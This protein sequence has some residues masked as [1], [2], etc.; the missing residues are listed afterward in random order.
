MSR[1]IYKDK[2]TKERIERSQGAKNVYINFDAITELPDEYECVI[3]EVRFDPKRLE[4]TFSPVGGGNYMPKPELMYEIAEACGIS[5]TGDPKIEPIIEEVDINP[6][7]MKPIGSE[8]TM[9]KMTIGRRVTKIS[10]R[11]QEDGTPRTSSPCT[12][13]YNAWERSVIKFAEWDD[14]KKSEKC[15]LST[16]QKRN[17]YFLSQELKFAHS[18]AETK[19]YEKSIRELA[20]LQTGYKIS[21]LS[22]GVLYFAKIRRSAM[23][24]KLETAARLDNI[25]NGGLPTAQQRQLEA[26]A[27]TEEPEA[28]P[29]DVIPHVEDDFELTP[30]EPEQPKTKREI[31]IDTF[32]FYREKNLIPE[33]DR[34]AWLKAIDTVTAWLKKNMLAE[35][36]EKLFNSAIDNLK[37]LENTIPSEVQKDHGLYVK[38]IF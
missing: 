2:Q 21:D 1:I 31:L 30:D 37:R 25:R 26:F 15:D 19:A 16:P 18:K 9:R 8:P 34:A 5:G 38:D 20:C 6:M 35:Q 4:D 33:K 28:K 11:I 24:L 12:C 29:V 36:N 27:Q 23:V 17:L 22:D 32:E 10:S 3:S 13:D 14:G 7:L